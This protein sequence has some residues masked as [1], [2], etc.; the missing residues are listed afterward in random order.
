VADLCGRLLWC[1]TAYR[2]DRHGTTMLVLT[3][4]LAAGASQLAL[5]WLDNALD[6]ARNGGS[7]KTERAMLLCERAAMLAHLGQL[8]LAS[9]AAWE[10]CDLAGERL[11]KVA[12][13]PILALAGVAMITRDDRLGARVLA[14]FDGRAGRD[15]NLLLRSTLLMMRG[16]L[17]KEHDARA[18]LE[19]FLD[20]GGALQ[21]AG[22]ANPLLFPWRAWTARVL[23]RLGDTESA[24]ASIEEEYERA[25][26][27]GA[28]VPLGRALRVR[29]SLT[30]GRAAVGLLAEAVDL[31][32]SSSDRL[33]LAIS[34]LEHGRV[35]R[36]HGLRGAQ[37]RLREAYRLAESCNAQWLAERVLA[38]AGWT[39]SSAPAASAGLS[40]A[41]RRVAE[42]AAGGMTNA[43]IAEELRVT[44]RAVEKH[45]TSCYRKLDITG[46]AELVEVFGTDSGLTIVR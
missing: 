46:R 39:G 32:R 4:L 11:G 9:A 1:E 7:T 23:R 18:A 24:M 27:W 45:L 12:D 26:A 25:R 33:E 44:R 16:A 38:V 21:S 6:I 8:G 37:D 40:E 43:D 15:A 2:G 42:L 30:G 10:A 3:S 14:C 29:A 31:L 28:P 34:L 19:H 5:P 17:A 22:W 36:D 20:C 41:E 13:I 35:L